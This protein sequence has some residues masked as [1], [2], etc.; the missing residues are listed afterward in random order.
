MMSLPGRAALFLLILIAGTT[1]I[2][3]SDL[4]MHR[5]AYQTIELRRYT[6]KPGEREHFLRYFEAYFPEAFQQLGALALGQFRERGN[7]QMF[8]WLR[9][10]KD[11]DARAV[12]NSTFYYGPLWKEHRTRM[13]DLLLDSDNVLLLRPL[14]PGRGVPVLPAVDVVNETAHGVIAAQIFAVKKDDIDAFAARA[15]SVFATYREAGVREAGVLVTLDVANNFPQLPVRTDG[16]YLVW[17]GMVE[18]DKAL[19][20]FRLLAE[21]ASRSLA[22]SGML[23][24]APE[25][26]VLDPAPRSR[27]RWLPE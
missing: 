2:F 23:R 18:N 17:L 19:D 10:F 15:E 4:T 6:I 12:V 11:I 14:A 24:S 8:T 7:P 9:G 13:N 16:P 20:R 25:L 26:L 27:L 22:D 1:S 3:G 21:D 5:D